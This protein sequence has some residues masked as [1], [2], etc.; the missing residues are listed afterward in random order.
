MNDGALVYLDANPF[1]YGLEGEP[2]ISEPIRVF[3]DSLRRRAGL[4][5]TSE[6]TIAEVLAPSSKGRRRRPD[7][8]REYLDLIIYGRF[9]ELEPVRLGILFETV[10]LRATAATGRLKLP[11]AIHLATAIGGGCRFFLTGDQRIPVPDGMR[12]VRLDAASL[13]EISEALQ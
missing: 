13:R 2:E 6:L 8:T 12:C 4:A 7:L 3:F 10:K 5:L 1:I 9:I 11:D